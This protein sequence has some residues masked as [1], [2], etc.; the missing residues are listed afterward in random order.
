MF[1]TNSTYPISETVHSQTPITPSLTQF[2]SKPGVGYTCNAIFVVIA[3][4]IIEGLS[5][6]PPANLNLNFQTSDEP[7]VFSLAVEDS[8]LVNGIFTSDV[9]DTRHHR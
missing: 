7:S 3:L 6:P 5:N 1:S 8:R 4:A 9:P 2:F